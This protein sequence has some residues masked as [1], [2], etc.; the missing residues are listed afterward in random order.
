VH[1]LAGRARDA[2]LA[3]EAALELYRRKGNVVCAVRLERL[4]AD[5]APA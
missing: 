4:V 2:R 1:D 5:H 3:R